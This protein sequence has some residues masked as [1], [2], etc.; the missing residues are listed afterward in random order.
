[1]Q[2]STEGGAPEQRHA[3]GY[4]TTLPAGNIYRTP[5]PILRALEIIGGKWKL[6]LLWRLAAGAARFN[7]LQRALTGITHM[8]LSKCLR[9]LER[10]GLVSRT[11]RGGKVR[12][13]QYALTERGRLLL[14]TLRE[15]Y[16]W[17][18]AQLAREGA[19]TGDAHAGNS[20][21]MPRAETASRDDMAR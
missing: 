7:A 21:A 19:R 20:L 12:H 16:R 8:M 14:P 6:P 1:M 4:D 17:G 5:C 15:L 11:D 2:N 18:E 13:V 3:P 10:D 9:E